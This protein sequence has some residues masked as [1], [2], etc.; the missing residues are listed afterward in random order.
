MIT[1]PVLVAV[2]VMNLVGVWLALRE[3]RLW[4]RAASLA[5]TV[6]S[7]AA[8]GSFLRLLQAYNSRPL[9]LVVATHN[10]LAGLGSWD[11][12]ALLLSLIAVIAGAFGADR[13]RIPV[14]VPGILMFC[15]T[16]FTLGAWD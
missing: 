11:L 7:I 12:L 3:P 4:R 1:I 15:L 14:M 6:A 13:A 16:L 10:P 5:A 9:G 2:A 8:A